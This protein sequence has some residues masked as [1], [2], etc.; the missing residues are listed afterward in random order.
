[1]RILRVIQTS[2]V[3]ITI[4]LQRKKTAGAVFMDIDESDKEVVHAVMSKERKGASMEP[5]LGF[6]R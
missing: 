4:F 5:L 2:N 1:M 3:S 6:A